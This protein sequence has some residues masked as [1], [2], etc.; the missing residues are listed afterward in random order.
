MLKKL[1][2]SAALLC[3]CMAASHYAQAQSAG[4]QYSLGF[5]KPVADT[6]GYSYH[7]SMRDYM[8]QPTFKLP[9]DTTGGKR[10][11]FHRKLFQEHLLE[12]KGEDYDFYASI[13]PDLQLG[14]SNDRNGALW[15]NTRGAIAGGRIGDRLTFYTEFYENQGKF[16]AYVDAFARKSRVVPGQGEWKDF[17]KGTAFDFAYASALINY[18]ASNHFDFQLGYDKNFIGDGYRSMLMSDVPFNYPFLKIIANVGRVQYTTMWAQFI[19]MQYPKA[20]YDNGYRKKWG[21]FNYLDWNV[22]KKF[23][24]G[25]FGAVVWQDS[26]STGKR[27][28]DASYLNP[29]IFLRPVEFSVGSSD[30]ALMGLNLKYAVS[31]NSAIYGQF[32]LDEFKLSEITKGN[33]WWGNKF[34]G[35][36]GFRSNNIFKVPN[37]NFLTEGNAARPFTYSQRTSL[38]NYGHYNQ[39]L[40]HPLGANFVEWVNIADYRYKRWFLR[41]ELMLAR[42]GLDTANT[43]YGKDIFKSYY[44]RTLDFDNH[45]GQGLATNLLYLQGTVAFLLNPKYNL[46]VEASVTAR[47]ESN[48][49]GRNNEFI[50]QIGLR[51]TFR[52]LYYDF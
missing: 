47:R 4:R 6:G 45:I 52:Q 33:G 26:D 48:D 3:C 21:V 40:A 28:F 51:S 30:N 2:I 38:N 19:D 22:S 44:T 49:L 37:L 29:I 35:Q 12:F 18:K 23:S 25:L 8:V 42:Y 15:L 17:S 27:G 7:S 20:S 14:H 50:F 24:A 1:Q 36:L 16:P 39:P 5:Y 43:N 11:W 46:R 34:G 10:S 32:V 41:G 9:E 13:L 31:N